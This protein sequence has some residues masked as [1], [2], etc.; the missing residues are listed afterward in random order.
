MP[1]AHPLP[2]NA[3]CVGGMS[4]HRCNALKIKVGL[5][6]TALAKRALPRITQR[7]NLENAWRTTMAH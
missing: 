6:T 3:S 7:R 2:M 5:C 1:R 4:T